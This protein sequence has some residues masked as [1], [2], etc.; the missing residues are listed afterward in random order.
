L[1]RFLTSPDA[2]KTLALTIGYKPTRKSLYNDRDLIREQPF[3]AGLYD[4]FMKARPRPVSPYYMM[5][6]Q[7]MQPE[8]SAAI[9]GIKSPEEALA[10]AQK[11]MGH[12]LEAEE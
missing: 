3:I 2:Q 9:S 6:T 7:V 1:V 12:I 10:S 5:I 8:F 4:V 11:L